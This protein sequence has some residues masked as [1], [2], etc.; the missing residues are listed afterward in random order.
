[1]ALTNEII[2]AN[3]SLKGLSEEQVSA[4]VTLSQNSEDELFREKMGEHYRKLDASIEEHSGVTRNGAEKTYDYLPRAIDAMKATF[5]ASMQ[6]LRTENEELKDK[7]AKG[8]DAAAKAQIESIQKELDATKSQFSVLKEQ[9]EKEKENYQKALNDY[10]IETEITRAMEGVKLKGG[11][12]EFA[13]KTLVSQAVANVKAKNPSF[14]DR[15]GE[16]RLVFHDENGLP[17]NNAENKLNP[18]TAKELLIKEFENLDILDRKPASGGGGKGNRPIQ[19]DVMS[20]STQIEA[21]ANITKALMAK[22]LLRGS[23]EFQSEFNKLWK[24]YNISSLPLR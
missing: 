18:F 1:M 7:V 17:L 21:T 20:A 11:L 15:G 10:K 22:G 4:I 6:Q 23:S 19:T 9:S 5:E 16:Q 13:L 24:E 2:A 14:E 12:N 8:G 3:E